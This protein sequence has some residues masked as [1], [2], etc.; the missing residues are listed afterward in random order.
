MVFPS[1]RDISTDL[2]WLREAQTLGSL[3]DCFAPK[4]LLRSFDVGVL[5]SEFAHQKWWFHGISLGYHGD[6]MWIYWVYVCI[7]IYIIYIYIYYVHIY[8]PIY[9]QQLMGR[10]C[11]TYV[12][13]QS[14]DPHRQEHAAC[15]TKRATVEGVVDM[16][17]A[18]RPM[19][20]SDNRV[21]LNPFVISL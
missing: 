11:Q 14:Q 15:S 6:I 2:N 1:L 5:L 17:S 18:L 4:Q 20:L 16:S 8:T 9:H 10:I 3:R 7:Y 19:G 12:V 13:C 21:P